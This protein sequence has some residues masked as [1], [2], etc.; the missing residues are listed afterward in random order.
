M[1]TEELQALGLS[2]EQIKEVFKL[3]G[4]DI[5]AEKK[6]ADAAEESAAQYKQR[7]E[8]AE[9]TLKG[10]DGVDVEKLNRDIED[11][12]KKAEEAEKD[13]KSQ[14][15]ERDFTDALK[16]ALDNVKFSSEAAKRS[17]MA[18]IKDAGLTL[19]D[20]EILGLNDVLRQIREKD[21][22]AFGTDEEGNPPARFTQPRKKESAGKPLTK[23]DIFNI[24]DANERQAAI[25][26][27][28]QLFKGE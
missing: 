9:E 27:N 12:K 5:N 19:K 21:A 6:R 1:K 20:G 16:T 15:Y 14:L 25:A 18:D 4:K 26:S 10:F 11:W 13:F 24:K 17:V 7:A 2:E 3:N 28:I 23:E 8:A 22:S